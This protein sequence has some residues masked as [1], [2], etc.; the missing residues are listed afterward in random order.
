MG[1]RIHDGGA[2][3]AFWEGWLASDAPGG[4]PHSSPPLWIPAFAGTTKWGAGLTK[5]MGR[6]DEGMPRMTNERLWEQ[7]IPDRSPGHAF[8]TIAHAG[9]CRHTE[10]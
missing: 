7:S 4:L 9:W 5:W 2:L 3:G 1:G 6:I 10:V 8:I